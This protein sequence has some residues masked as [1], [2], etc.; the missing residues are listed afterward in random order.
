MPDWPDA[1][2]V[3]DVLRDIMDR[4][5]EPLQ[6]VSMDDLNAGF[7]RARNAHS[8]D[9]DADVFYLAAL[10]FDGIATRHPLLD[11]NKRLSLLAMLTFLDMNDATPDMRERDL[12]ELCTARVRKD[13]STEEMASALRASV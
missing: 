7:M 13:I 6:I 4:Q 2:E 12:Y 9:P 8:Y 5:D 3:I 10:M 1:Q 11:G